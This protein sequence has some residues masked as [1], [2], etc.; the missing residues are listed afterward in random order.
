MHPIISTEISW[1]NQSLLAANHGNRVLESFRTVK[2]FNV[3]I[4]LAITDL[5]ADHL[6]LF[7]GS[8]IFFYQ[9]YRRISLYCFIHASLDTNLFCTDIIS[10]KFLDTRSSGESR[11]CNTKICGNS[12][13]EYY[14]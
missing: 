2:E 8:H 12:F 14:C 11:T 6:Y 13:F 1:R 5:A 7:L 9:Q 4:L 10:H 3:P